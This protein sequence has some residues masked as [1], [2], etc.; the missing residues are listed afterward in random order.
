[1]PNY[2]TET[3]TV[4]NSNDFSFIVSLFAESVAQYLQKAYHNLCIAAIALAICIF[5]SLWIVYKA[6]KIWTENWEGW[7]KNFISVLV[8]VAI[9]CVVTIFLKNTSLLY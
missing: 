9:F 1:M 7:I 3:T 6:T 5:L 8:G 2:F 4:S